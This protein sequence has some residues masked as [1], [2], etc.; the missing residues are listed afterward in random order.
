MAKFGPQPWTNPF[1]KKSIF[2]VFLTSCFYSIQRCFFVLE[3]NNIHFPSLQS[4]K[5]KRGEMKNLDQ[6]HGLTP[7]EACQF[8]AFLNFMFLQPRRG[9]FLFQNIIKHMFLAYIA[10][11]RRWK[12]ANFGRKPWTNSF[13]RVSIFGLFSTSC[14]YSLQ[15]FFSFQNIMKQICLAY[16]AQKRRWKNGQFWTKTMD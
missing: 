10:Q 2:G 14:F 13:G 16:I 7:L 3:Y 9:I 11:K 1:G 4:Q 8:F 6:N 12:M 15:S 5:K